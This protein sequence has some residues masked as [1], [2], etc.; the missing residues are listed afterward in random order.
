MGIDIVILTKNEAGN[1]PGCLA[2]FAGLGQAV[3]IDDGSSDD[4]VRLAREAGAVVYER[5]MDDFSGQRNFALEKSGAEWVFFLDAD[6][7][8]TPGLVEA[9][10]AHV[11]GP[12]AAG[13]V[14]RKN[15]AFGQR[16]R[17]GHLAPDW[18]TRLFPRGEVRWVGEVHERAETG[19]PVVALGGH[20]EHLT[21]RDWEHYLGKMERY[22]RI[23]ALEAARKGKR[24]GVVGALAKAS[25]NYFK[26]MVLKLGVLDGPRGWAVCAISGYY[27]LSKYLILNGLGDKAK[28]GGR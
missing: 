6:E 15:F 14:L 5:A 17:F 24:C 16:F 11:A 19:L 1:L 13:R 2:S 25:A 12:R 4:T 10:R 8:F 23:W 26:T 28:A 18:V 9:V 7:R 21:Y 22:A 3:I 27:T 20:M